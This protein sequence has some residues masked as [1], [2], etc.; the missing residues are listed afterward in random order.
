MVFILNTS[1]P[2]GE[3]QRE[4]AGANRF[5][6][7]RYPTDFT[8]AKITFRLKGELIQRGADL[9]LL[10]QGTANGLTSGWVLTGQPLEVTPT[11]AERTLTLAPDP[12][13]WRCL[14][15]RHDR[16]DMY[17]VLPLDRILRAVTNNIMVHPLPAR[18][19]TDG[20]ARRR[21]AQAPGRPRLPRVARQATGGLRDARRGANRLRVPVGRVSV[22][23]RGSAPVRGHVRCDVRDRVD[24]D[25]VRRVGAVRAEAVQGVGERGLASARSTSWPTHTSH[26]PPEVA[27]PSSVRI[28]SALAPSISVP[29]AGR[30][31]RSPASSG[32][33]PGSLVGQEVAGDNRHVA[34]AFGAD[35]HEVLAAGVGEAPGRR[36]KEL[37]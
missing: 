34:P 30:G 14:G 11:W 28:S 18:R 16:T 25:P 19:G 35:A 32:T 5:I 17:G 29:R 24:P 26:C 36:A 23:P 15:S 22:G 10:C 37:R 21:P 8:D 27:R 7:G 31:R 2:Q 12:K 3:H 33:R 6:E 9:V 4:V 20:T 13:Q 1:G